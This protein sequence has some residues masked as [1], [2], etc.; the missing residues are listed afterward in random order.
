MGLQFLAQSASQVCTDPP[1]TNGARHQQQSVD[2]LVAIGELS[3]RARLIAATLGWLFCLV[4]T[5]FFRH[6]P[7]GQS[8]C[9][10]NSAERHSSAERHRAIKCWLQPARR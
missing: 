6:C 10:K 8:A 1:Q 5:L 7:T 3:L 2:Q 4:E 9:W